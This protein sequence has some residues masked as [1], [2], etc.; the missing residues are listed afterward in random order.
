MSQKVKAR[1]EE[2]KRETEMLNRKRGQ[3][4]ES[5][6]IEDLLTLIPIFKEFNKNG[7]EAEIV[8]FNKM[9]DEIIDWALKLVEKNMKKIYEDTWGWN[10][11]T[12]E[13][14]LIHESAR[15]LIAFAGGKPIG[16]IHFRFEL[17][18][19]ETSSFIYDI[20]IEEG[21][22]RKGLGRFLLQAV[23]FIT[24]KLKLDSVMVSVFK[25]NVAGR[26]FFHSM[27]YIQHKTS[28]VVSD[29][30]NAHEYDNEI[31]FKPLVKNT[32]K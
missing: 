27:K 11:D 8:S 24:L 19:G 32:P 21:F 13:G 17:E 5:E 2:R 15:F 3:I 14:E 1:K 12:K 28:P 20:Q 25:E 16:F 23:E 4:K 7:I 26:A 31:L 10:A 9:P 30:E 18:N 22:V 6:A 29:P